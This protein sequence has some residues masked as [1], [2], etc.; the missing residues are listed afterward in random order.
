MNTDLPIGEANINV[1]PFQEANTDV[2]LLK[3]LRLAFMKL[4][5]EKKKL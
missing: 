5:L 4:G 3:I 2:S 1:S